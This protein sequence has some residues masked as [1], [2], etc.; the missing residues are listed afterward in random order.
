MYLFTRQNPKEPVLLTVK[1]AKVLADGKPVK[2][3]IHG[4][5]NH[6]LME[7]VNDTRKAYLQKGDFNVVQVDWGGLASKFY[8]I[9]AD[10]TRGLG[11]IIANVLVVS[12]VP[13][14]Q[15]HLV[16]H[17]LGAQTAGVIGRNIKRRTGSQIY[18]IIGL[19]P[20]RP[21]FEDVP[22][23]VK[24]SKS[25]A[26]MVEVIHSDGGRFGMI[27]STGTVDFYPNGGTAEQPKC[28]DINASDLLNIV[29]LVMDAVACSHGRSIAYFIESINSPGFIG[30]KCQNWIYFIMGFCAFNE[31]I[32]MGDDTPVTA[33]GTYFLTTNEEPPYARSSP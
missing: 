15:I 17:S 30:I 19:D 20:A 23:E 4:W 6:G 3:V 29:N 16:G 1:N 10:G 2:V 12:G 25:D 22:V 11:D 31:R 14:S 26:A 5:Q 32:V 27:G 21:L 18:K 8:S 24:L 28:F 33:E 9:S 13:P 7:W